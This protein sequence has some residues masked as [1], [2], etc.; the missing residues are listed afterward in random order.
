MKFLKLSL[1]ATVGA[2]AL[3]GAAQAADRPL[4]LVLNAGASTDY[5]FRGLTQT[6][7]DPE[8][9][10]GADIT[11]AK[12]FYAGT[13]VSNVDFADPYIAGTRS[14][15]DIE[16][17]LYAGVKPTLGPVSFDFGAIRYGYTHG[18][19]NKF[20]YYELKALGSMPVGPVTVGASFFYSPN[21]FGLGNINAYYYELNA[22]G[23]IPNTKFSV[24]GAVGRQEFQG[25]GDYTTWN[26]GVGY[27]LND[28]VSFDF[29]YWDT[30][31]SESS[32]GGFYGNT[33]AARFVAGLKATF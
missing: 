10:G 20:D 32:F 1:L 18:G 21:T 23:A 33:G 27:A 31:L 29:R 28:T 25:P 3:A 16:Y 24:S 15:S 8:I 2:V 5:E 7:H 4:G 13:W 9:F 17:D 11:V 22:N 30:N 12:I 26:L 6:N 19:S 14:S